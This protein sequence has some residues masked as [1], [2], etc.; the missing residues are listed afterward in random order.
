MYW[1]DAV[2]WHGVADNYAMLRIGKNRLIFKI[3]SPIDL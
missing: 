3:L 2:L 1:E